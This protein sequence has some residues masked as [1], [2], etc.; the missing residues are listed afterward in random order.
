NRDSDIYLTCNSQCDEAYPVCEKYILNT[1]SAGCRKGKRE[2][3][4]AASARGSS[5]KSSRALRSKDA[6]CESSNSSGDDHEANGTDKL[7]LILDKDEL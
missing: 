5:S 6:D 4:Y 1:Q 3:H 2:C 7:P